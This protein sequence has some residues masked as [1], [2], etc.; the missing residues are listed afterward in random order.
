MT[1]FLLAPVYLLV[2]VY[3]LSW[4][5]RWID[6]WLIRPKKI[7]IIVAILYVLLCLTP[8][9]YFL[10]SSLFLKKIMA[11]INN[12]WM[13]IFLYL[14]L[15]ILIFDLIR[16]ITKLPGIKRYIPQTKRFFVLMG[17]IA[18]ILIVGIS[19]YGMYQARKIRV[20]K[21]SVEIASE[22]MK[23]QKLK[24]ALIADLH[25]GYSIGYPHVKQMVE[26]INA[27]HPDLVCIAG[28]I[29]D[30]HFESIENPEKIKEAL[31]SITSKYG[32][33]A[34]Y[35]NHDY[36]EQ[37]LA[38]FTFSSKEPVNIGT[39]MREF[40]R[41]A[42][43][44]TLEDEAVLIHQKFYLV[45]RKDYSTRGKTGRSRMSP[46][47]LLQNLDKTKPI[48][49]IDHQPK[50]ITELSD[51]GANLDLCGHTHDGQ[52]FPGNIVT[53]MMWENSYGYLKEGNMHQIVTSG[54]GVFGPYM[55]VGTKSEIVEVNVSFY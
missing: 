38:G 34:C 52:L 39:Q 8:L 20:T 41:E 29:F 25:M 42:N 36:E 23:N 37:I 48:I 14:L 18:M 21:Y 11:Q 46:D 54:V 55:R 51:A 32:V 16:W 33:Y 5:F 22:A 31:A 30:N 6:A 44:Q 12:Y 2:N 47:E 19:T 28:D 40:L 10:C 13:G 35:G 24:I 50:Q 3:L 9:F 27:L 15:V 43:I 53:R 26:K 4:I 49:V 45:G 7:K 1:A 17:S